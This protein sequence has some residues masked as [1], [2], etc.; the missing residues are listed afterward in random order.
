[1]LTPIKRILLL[2]LAAPL[3]LMAAPV[4][5]TTHSAGIIDLNSVSLG[6]AYSVM[7]VLGLEPPTTT[8]PLPYELTIEANFDTDTM[9]SPQA[10]W[11]Y[12]Y[13]GDVAVAFK[14]GTQAYHFAGPGNSTVNLYDQ[15]VYVA[16][17]GH[18][19]W[20][21]TPDDIYGFY[22]H[23]LGPPASLGIFNPL[24]ALYADQNDGV[25]GSATI[26][27]DP[28]A[29]DVQDVFSIQGSGPVM[30]VHVAP[31]P[32]P[33]PFAMLA[34]GL[35]M[36]GLLRRHSGNRCSRTRARYPGC[37]GRWRLMQSCVSAGGPDTGI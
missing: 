32:E 6:Y 18:S 2:L 23:L 22:H 20:F 4:T 14:I 29:N 21:E 25:S 31:I 8:G 11:A 28:Q 17:Y 1:M 5:V 12:S 35:V 30:S 33:A 13:G 3:A 37:V 16:D 15:S 36:L 27:L 7:N 19:V 34:A 9:V 24:A 10:F 26:F